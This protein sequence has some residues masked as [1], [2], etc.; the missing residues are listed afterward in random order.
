MDHICT[1]CFL[2]ST[3]HPMDCDCG[4]NHWPPLCCPGCDCGSVEGAHP[5]KDDLTREE[6][7]SLI[8]DHW[9]RL[10]HNAYDL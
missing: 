4:E 6:R 3:D 5:H 8:P 7:L 1:V 9:E 10:Q 2:P